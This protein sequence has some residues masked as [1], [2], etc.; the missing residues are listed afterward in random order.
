[1]RL[2]DGIRKLGFRKW[3]SRELTR[4]HLQLLMLL[5]ST[6]GLF[7]AVELVGRPAPTPER[8][9][10]L[11]LLLV[12]LGVALWSL[13]RY[14]FLFKRAEVIATQAVCPSCRA[15]GRLQVRESADDG[16]QVSVSCLK[17][18]KQWQICDPGTGL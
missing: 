14:L 16:E 8:L 15:Y 2:D 1:M 6:I 9:G 7:A 4:A 10:N 18:S 12:C 11:L 17:C 13:R 3:Y 5:L